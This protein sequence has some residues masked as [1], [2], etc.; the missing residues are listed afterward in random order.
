MWYFEPG[1]ETFSNGARLS[2]LYGCLGPDWVVLAADRRVEIRE[3]GEVRATSARKLFALGRH[4]AI[5]SS[6]AAVGIRISLEVAQLLADRPL[7]DLDEVE[8]FVVDHFQRRYDEFLAQGEEWFRC[9]PEALTLSYFMLAGVDADGAPRLR[10]YASERHGD[11]YRALPVGQV[12]TAPRRLG[13][14]ARFL[15]ALKGGVSAHDARAMAVG[16]LRRIA[17]KEHSVAPPFDFAVIDVAGANL[18][19]FEEI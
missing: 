16:D 18:E 19:T 11:P 12:L 15:N 13:S 7:P 14:E 3:E 1:P 8:G 2:Q 6:G 5:A 17:A 4:G 10:F 9:H